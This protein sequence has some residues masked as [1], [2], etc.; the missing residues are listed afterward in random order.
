MKSKAFDHSKYKDW[1]DPEAVTPYEHNEGKEKWVVY[2][3][4]FPNNKK[5]IGITSRNPLY[6]WVEGGKGY[7]KQSLVWNAIQKYG[8][9][10]VMHLILAETETQEDAEYFEKY[11]IALFQS[12]NRKYGYNV[13]EGGRCAKGHKLSEV[14]RRRMSEARTGEK[15]WIYGKH[16][17]EETKKKLSASHKGKVNLDAIK[18]GAKKRMGANAYNSRAVRCYD[19]E[20]NIIGEYKALADGARAIGVKPQDI[21]NCCIGRQKTTHGTRW[22]YIDLQGV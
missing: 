8:W 3:H 9:E 16:L 6:R 10:N 13:T 1:I 14:T 22:E 5:Y 7:K 4:T 11:Y 21:Y 2:M 18:R 20:G 12:N 19:G 15:N 17:T